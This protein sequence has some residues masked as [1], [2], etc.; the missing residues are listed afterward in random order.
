MIG[1]RNLLRW[2]CVLTAC[3]SVACGVDAGGTGA[4]H[5]DGGAGPPPIVTGIGGGGGQGAASGAGA[6]SSGG[7]GAAAGTTPVAADGGAQASTDGGVVL[8]SD[9]A[10]A[11]AASACGCR[12]GQQCDPAL[13]CVDCLMDSQCPASSRFC[14]QGLCV[15][16]K[17]NGDCGAGTTPAC[18]PASHTCHPAC[19]SSQ[20]C[21]DGNATI[22]NTST[23]ACVG[24]N[25]SADCPTSQK[26]CDPTTQQCVQCVSTADCAGTSTPV[27]VR[28]RCA[29]CATSADCSGATPYC[30]AGGDNGPRCAQ[31]LQSAQCPP[32]APN[33]N[34]GTCSKD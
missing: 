15:Q 2:P 25:T 12:P 32:S 27:C 9:A 16:C 17:A 21:Q 34:S 10:G 24:C 7:S 28:N 3:F 22:C 14:V 5:G 1:S 8:A 18:W 4:S 26:F 23:G 31:C 20:Q 33:C 29:E 11:E 6:G 13:G 30:N 19:T